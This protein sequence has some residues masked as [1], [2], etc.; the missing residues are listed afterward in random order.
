[1][2]QNGLIHLRPDH[3][4]ISL[5]LSGGF[6]LVLLHAW[7]KCLMVSGKTGFSHKR[8]RKRK[9]ILVPYAD[10]QNDTKR[11]MVKQG[12]EEGTGLHLH[13]QKVNKNVVENW[14]SPFLRINNFNATLILANQNSVF[15]IF[16]DTK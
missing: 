12:E 10:I 16:H 1:M 13:L 5:S 15:L 4:T 3:I 7:A 9:L 11:V 6:I 8:E 2:E 14:K